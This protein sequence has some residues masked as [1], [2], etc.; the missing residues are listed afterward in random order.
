MDR[1]P[2]EV[3]VENGRATG[4]FF[5]KGK[6]LP[7]AGT[8]DAGGKI[9]MNVPAAPE[10]NYSAS[11]YRSPTD[12]IWRGTGQFANPTPELTRCYNNYIALSQ[13]PSSIQAPQR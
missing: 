9:V 12:G 8:I 5:A 2:V 4:L 6:N 3:N 7:T 1:V 13:T 10:L 11:V